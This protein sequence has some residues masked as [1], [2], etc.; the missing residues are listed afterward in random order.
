MISGIRP[1]VVGLGY[2][3]LPLLAAFS[4]HFPAIGYDKNKTRI[5]QLKAKIDVTNE[6][7][8]EDLLGIS[9]SNYLKDL[10]EVN[11]YI[12]TV[13]TPIDKFNNPDLSLLHS[14]TRDIGSLLKH[15]DV[16]VYESTV[17]PGA[18]EET[19][20]PILEEVSGLKFNKDFSVGYSPERINPGDRDRTIE[21]ITKITSGSSAESADVIDKVYSTV[22]TAGTF[23]A[24]SIKIAEAAK[25]IENVQRDINIALMNELSRLFDELNVDT[26]EVLAA[27]ST[28]WNFLPFQPGLVGGHCIGVDPYYLTHKA[29]EVGFHPELIS[30]S[31]RINDNMSEFVAEKI[32]R[33]LIERK[34]DFSK[35]EILILGCTFKENCPD[36]RNSKVIDLYQHILKRGI[37]AKISDPLANVEEVK[38]KY[39]IEISN[40]LPDKKFTAL[41]FAVKHDQYLN[42]PIEEINKLRVDS[43]LIFDLKYCLTQD[44]D[45]IRI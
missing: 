1:G 26:K 35:L 11:F 2:V 23:R 45:A 10:K 18:V 27:A 6:L 7:K 12:I 39:G 15:D 43:G 13:P 28:K 17:F 30:A 14:A 33:C 4:K 41:V 40:E 31:R 3:G 22:I 36:V 19:C 21:K 42:Y 24:S 16:V 8:S 37:K 25:V 44:V 32:F 20:V 38:L 34:I 5:D 9:I 29:N